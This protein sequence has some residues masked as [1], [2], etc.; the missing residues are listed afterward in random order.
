MF[1]VGVLVEFAVVLGGFGGGVVSH[2]MG[3]FSFQD[4]W[5]GGLFERAGSGKR[6]FG[7]ENY[8]DHT[9]RKSLCLCVRVIFPF[10]IANVSLRC[11]ICKAKLNASMMEAKNLFG[12]AFEKL[13]YVQFSISITSNSKKFLTKIDKK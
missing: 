13:V 11:W 8:S 12:I 2:V 6:R 1:L 9:E 7:F 5:N 4:A 3:D 10:L